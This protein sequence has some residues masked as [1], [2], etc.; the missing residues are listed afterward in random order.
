MAL[1]M[2]NDMSVGSAIC[3]GIIISVPCGLLNGLLVSFGNLQPFIVTLGT[4]SI[5]RGIALI[6]TGGIPIYGFP[7]AFRWF[8]T[9][10]VG[11]V[12]IAAI[13]SLIVAVV[14]AFLFNK[15]KVGHYATAIGSTKRRC[16]CVVLM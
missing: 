5:V 1:A 8:G 14:A 10:R 16:G 7:K 6:L 3:L 9:G 12:P 13:I 4:M 15:T 2:K 11:G